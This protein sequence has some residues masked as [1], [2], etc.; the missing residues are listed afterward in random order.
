[1]CIKENFVIL[2]PIRWEV[3]EWGECQQCGTGVQF[4][5][6]QCVILTLEHQ[7]GDLA[8]FGVEKGDLVTNPV[9]VVQDKQCGGER[10]PNV[11]TCYKVCPAG[12]HSTFLQFKSVIH[13]PVTMYYQGAPPAHSIN[14][15]DNPFIFIQHALH[16]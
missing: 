16:I 11:Q 5:Q 10:P 12:K 9:L 13:K 14:S 15:L 8:G 2:N 4:R 6:V 1:M 7:D 3:G